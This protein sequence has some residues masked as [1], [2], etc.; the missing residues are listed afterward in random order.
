MVYCSHGI[1]SA[2]VAEKMQRGG[3]EAYSFRGGVRGVRAW[4]ETHPVTS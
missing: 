2:H 1:Q 3:Y 4:A